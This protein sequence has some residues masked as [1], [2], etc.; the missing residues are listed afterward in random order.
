MANRLYLVDSTQ[1][2]I[3][4]WCGHCAALNFH[5]AVTELELGAA[6]AAESET[7]T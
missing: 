6:E 5:V 7:N 3:T 4:R 2:D 1:H